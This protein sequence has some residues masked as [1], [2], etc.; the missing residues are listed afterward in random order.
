VTGEAGR[1]PFEL[2]PGICLTTEEKLGK[3]G[4]RVASGL[5][6]APTWLSFEGQPRLACCTSD[7]LGY[8][9][10]SVSPRSAQA[11]SK[12]KS[13]TTTISRTSGVVLC[14]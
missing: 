2:C 1:A 9:G 11:H 8:L 7:H 5:I 3:K 6:V 13:L 4:I 14:V 12:T 10:A